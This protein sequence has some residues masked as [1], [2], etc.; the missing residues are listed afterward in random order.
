MRVAIFGGTGFVGSYII[1]E[2]IKKQHYIS[3]FAKKTNPVITA[4]KS[5]YIDIINGDSSNIKD[6]KKTIL[7]C[8]IVIYSI[9]ILREFANEGIT[10][11]NTHF[12]IAKKCIDTSV[13]F[14]VKRFIMISANGASL[15]GTDYQRTK[16]LA[17]K[18]LKKSS[19]KYTIFRPSVIFG[20]P[21]HPEHKDFTTILNKT[22]IDFPIFAP[23]FFQGF[24]FYNAGH[25][26]ISPIFVKDVAK[27]IVA[28]IENKKCENQTYTMC[29]KNLTWN[30]IIKILAKHRH[31]NKIFIPIPI[32]I[33]KFI[34]TIFS[35]FH[36]FPTSKDELTM[37]MQ[38]NVC[39]KKDDIF[40]LLDMQKKYF[41][42]TIHF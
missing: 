16:F 23:S 29:G 22:I 39:D 13:D 9:G 19:I 3:V 15:S 21:K 12:N 32:F 7:N 30:K 8:D 35:R 28:S 36:F 6:I 37:L 25:S 2:L 11:E 4:T 31:K 17:E 38:D 27:A 10:F 18:Y 40:K 41:N 5:M 34:A 33:A 42:T 1:D 26:K 20:K 14:G 24:K